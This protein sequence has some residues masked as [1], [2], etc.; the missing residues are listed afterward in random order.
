MK[1]R[2]SISQFAKRVG[3]SR[4]TLIYYDKIDLFKPYYVDDNQ[5]RYYLEDQVAELVEILQMRD[6]GIKL[7]DIKQVMR[8]KNASSILP[9]LD[10]H[11]TILDQKIMELQTQKLL[12]HHRKKYYECLFGQFELNKIFLKEEKKRFALFTPF[13]QRLPLQEMIDKAYQGCV[14][15][16][17]RVNGVQ[18]DGCGVM[19]KCCVYN[20]NTHLNEGGVYFEVSNIPEDF[21]NL[22][23]LP[24][25]LKAEKYFYGN[26][27]QPEQGK[28]VE[29]YIKKMGYSCQCGMILLHNIVENQFI[30]GEKDLSLLEVPIYKKA[31]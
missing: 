23:E 1:Q 2:Y 24:G 26:P 8:D 29:E 6:V 18:F 17:I 30:A 27:G 13:D 11:L 16:I 3:I 10:E 21:P 19:M 15:K 25:G 4:Q 9:L 5:Y 22:I 31:G 28:D 7:E 14:E 20:K 12:L